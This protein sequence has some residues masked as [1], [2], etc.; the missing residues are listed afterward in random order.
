MLQSIR[1]NSQG[2]GAKIVIGF[3]IALMSMFGIETMFRGLISGP[4]VA[5]I[6]GTEVTEV[7]LTTGVQ[8]LVMSLGGNAGTLDDALLREIALNQIIE[9]RL[10][11][12]AAEDAN[13]R[14]SS[15]AIDRQLINT[16]Q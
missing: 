8:N 6:D 15:D 13:M 5:E 7:E 3:I 12:K 11:R 16:A 1:D 9:D 2:V 14:I 4:A 10:L